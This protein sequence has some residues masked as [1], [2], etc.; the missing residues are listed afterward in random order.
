MGSS[1][2]NYVS[3]PFKKYTNLFIKNTFLK[4]IYIETKYNSLKIE[5]NSKDF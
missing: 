3:Y 5:Y 4:F 1:K 2:I